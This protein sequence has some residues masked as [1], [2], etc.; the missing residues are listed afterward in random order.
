MSSNFLWETDTKVL[1]HSIMSS[2]PKLLRLRGCNCNSEKCSP[3]DKN[4]TQIILK[5]H[6]SM[7]GQMP[8]SPWK[9]GQSLA[10]ILT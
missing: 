8:Y 7:M 3:Q 2:E 9:V 1:L 4:R 6:F 5:Q 10:E